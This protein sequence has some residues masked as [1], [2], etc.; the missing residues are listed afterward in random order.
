MLV[1]QCK[2]G[3]LG[4]GAEFRGSRGVYIEL[5]DPLVRVRYFTGSSDRE[6]R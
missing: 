2:T 5:I 4:F 3:S 6:I 1:A